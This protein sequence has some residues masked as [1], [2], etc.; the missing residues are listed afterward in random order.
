MASGLG[1]DPRV[2]THLPHLAEASY[3]PCKQSQA[4]S[5]RGAPAGVDRQPPDSQELPNIIS[6]C[7]GL[8]GRL[9]NWSAFCIF[10]LWAST[11]YPHV[12][13]I[14]V[15]NFFNLRINGVFFFFS[16]FPQMNIKYSKRRNLPVAGS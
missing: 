5:A 12:A 10:F 2:Q 15:K 16:G 8:P 7:G 14:S 6:S 9:P 13:R 4:G 11:C 3:L 1:S